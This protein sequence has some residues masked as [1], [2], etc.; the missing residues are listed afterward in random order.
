M[1]S[2]MPCGVTIVGKTSPFKASLSS[3]GRV[4]FSAASMGVAAGAVGGANFC[5]NSFERHEEDDDSARH[6]RRAG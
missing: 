2:G 1:T 5:Q 6:L 4:G 3:D